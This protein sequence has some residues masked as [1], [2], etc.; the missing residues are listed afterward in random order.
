MGLFDLP[1]ER[2]VI[3]IIDKV[4]GTGKTF[5][6]KYVIGHFGQSRVASMDLG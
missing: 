3:W 5:F 1:T 6:Q 4:G 2:E